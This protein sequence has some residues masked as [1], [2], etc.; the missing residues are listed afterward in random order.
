VISRFVNRQFYLYEP[1][2]RAKYLELLG[3]AVEKSDAVLLGY[4]LMSS[5]VHLIFRAGNDPLE[6][7]MKSV[8]SG[9]AGWFNRGKK[10]RQ[11]PVFAGRYKAILVDEEEY[12]LELVRYVHNNPV[13]AR[14]VEEARQ[15]SWSSHQ[16]YVGDVEAPAWLNGGY[17][18]SMFNEK[19][20]WAR[21]KFDRFVLDGRDEKRR[22]DLN[23]EEQDRA[24]RRFQSGFG[25][26]WRLSGPMVGSEQF[27][28][29]VMEDL[30]EINA[31]VEQGVPVKV[32]RSRS[33]PELKELIGVTCAELGLES[34]EFEN[35]PKAKRAALARRVILYLWVNEYGGRQADVARAMHADSG[36]VARW[37]TKALKDAGDLEPLC[38]RIK[39]QFPSILSQED[40]DPKVRYSF[41]IE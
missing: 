34:W 18:L 10:R 11:G 23:G 22:K 16:A 32:K 17:I 39:S 36:A 31:Q 26:S 4:C 6:R 27:A 20:G 28:A 33:Q 14:K 30:H 21:R 38:S 8:H 1:G 37:Y 24:T 12:L 15:S 40:M 9:Y 2:G 7:V 41:E 29:K 25:D 3:G 35:Q 19:A 13:R 5:H